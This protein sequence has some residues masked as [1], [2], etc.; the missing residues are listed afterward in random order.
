[1]NTFAAIAKTEQVLDTMATAPADYAAQ[2]TALVASGYSDK[3]PLGVAGKPVA[4]VAVILD[5]IKAAYRDAG[6][7]TAKALR[8]RTLRL[9]YAIH[10][11]AANPKR[12]E[13]TEENYVKRCARI[14]AMANAGDR[15]QIDK[16]IAGSTAKPKRAARPNSGKASKATPKPAA[17]VEEVEEVSPAA[18]YDQAHNALVKAL[19]DYMAAMDAYR[20]NGGKVTK[21]ASSAV[22][23]RAQALIAALVA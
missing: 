8:Q 19:G 10:I 13:E 3:L 23:T 22:T 4:A 17:T 15:A 11:L 21:A 6:V 14:R 20:A 16:A 18:A 12:D 9:T 2:L 5:Q 1:M 7:T